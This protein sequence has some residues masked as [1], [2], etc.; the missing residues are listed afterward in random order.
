M[1]ACLVLTCMAL[2]SLYINSLSKLTKSKITNLDEKEQLA[3]NNIQKDLVQ[4]FDL[5]I[6]KLIDQITSKWS[7]EANDIF[8]KNVKGLESSL[9][10]KLNDIYKNEN[11]SLTNYKKTK[12]NEFEVELK[13]Y[14]KK[15]SRQVL[16]H[17]IDPDTH[18]KLI[19]DSLEAVIKNGLFN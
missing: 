13:E 2:V 9:V 17:E 4:K 6:A 18:K 11:D 14:L 5:A 19:K 16:K 15:V 8:A 1:F 12:K 10:N 7:K 3:L